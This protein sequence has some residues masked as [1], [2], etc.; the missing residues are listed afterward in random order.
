MNVDTGLHGLLEDPRCFGFSLRDPQDDQTGLA[1]EAALGLSAG[2]VVAA[3][4]RAVDHTEIM[5][6]FRCRHAGKFPRAEA[7]TALQAGGLIRFR[8]LLAH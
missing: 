6:F 8:L 5:G 1:V 7:M 3:T 2:N 4:R